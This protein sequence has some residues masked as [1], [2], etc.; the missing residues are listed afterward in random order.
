MEGRGDIPA[1]I[2]IFTTMEKRKSGKGRLGLSDPVKGEAE[3]TSQLYLPRR[4][5]MAS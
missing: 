1:T 2:D 5:Q 4:R 3:Y